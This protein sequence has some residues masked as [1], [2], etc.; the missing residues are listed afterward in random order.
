M[1][2]ELFVEEIFHVFIGIV[3]VVPILREDL[4]FFGELVKVPF[5]F[6]IDG[7][8]PMSC[9][10][11]RIGGCG[12]HFSVLCAPRQFGIHIARFEI[13][14]QKLSAVRFCVFP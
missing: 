8:I 2:V 13:V 7:T 14:R 3:G 9:A 6:F 11:H 5:K 1:G 4:V 10:E 12:E